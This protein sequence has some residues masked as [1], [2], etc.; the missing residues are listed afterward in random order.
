MWSD[1]VQEHV[2]NLRNVGPLET[3]THQGVAGVP[4]EGPYMRLWFEVNEGRIVRAAY[5]TY[6]CVSA[7]ASGSITATLLT[8]LP[9]ERALLLTAEDLLRIMGGLPEGKEHYTQLAVTAIA[10]AL[11]GD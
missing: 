11:K 2:S 8:G 6:G 3:A 10:N 5:K 9:V 7:I 1:L 4:G